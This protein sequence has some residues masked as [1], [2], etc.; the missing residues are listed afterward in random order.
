MRTYRSGLYLAVICILITPCCAQSE[1]PGTMASNCSVS[2]RDGL[3]TMECPIRYMDR[4]A[5]PR[6]P[7]DPVPLERLQ[8]P[9]MVCPDTLQVLSRLWDL[10]DS[11]DLYCVYIV[12]PEQGDSFEPERNHF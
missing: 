1:S 12:R 8:Q 6:P 2:D 5:G 9:L 3:L 10:S 7:A 11:N 4:E